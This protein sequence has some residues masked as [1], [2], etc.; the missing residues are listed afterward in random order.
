MRYLAPAVVMV[1]L[2]LC[3]RSLKNYTKTDRPIMNRVIEHSR[4]SE[5]ATFSVS[6]LVQ[7]YEKENQKVSEKNTAIMQ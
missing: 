4:N 6:Q 3:V 1:F 7:S 2:S 5:P